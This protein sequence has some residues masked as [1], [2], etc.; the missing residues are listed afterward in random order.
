MSENQSDTKQQSCGNCAFKKRA[1]GHG[2]GFEYCSHP[3]SPKG[4]GN[5]IENCT[6]HWCPLTAQIEKMPESNVDYKECIRQLLIG[7]E[8][9]NIDELIHELETRTGPEQG[10][11]FLGEKHREDVSQRLRSDRCSLDKFEKWLRDNLVSEFS[12]NVRDGLYDNKPE[13]R[14]ESQ[15][16]MFEKLGFVVAKIAEYKKEML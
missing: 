12:R 11:K 7:L 2:E 4:Y 10:Y 8:F 3:G 9:R 5:V 14:D 16:D 1:T 15:N 13:E 6:P